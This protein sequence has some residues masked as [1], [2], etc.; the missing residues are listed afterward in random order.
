[1]PQKKF[2]ITP[3][4]EKASH[5]RFIKFD[6]EKNDKALSQQPDLVHL[7][8]ESDIEIDIELA[9]KKVHRTSRITVTDSLDPV[10][11][12][13]LHDVLTLPDGT[14]KERPHKQTL[15][16]INT[17]IPVRISEELETPRDLMFRYLFRKS[18]YITHY[19][20]V[21]YK[22]L[23]EIAEKL[24]KAKKFARVD[25]FNPETNKRGKKYRLVLH[26][27]DQELN[28]TQGD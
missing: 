9:G 12:Y 10:Y 13:S 8:K 15:G 4:G 2:H 19:D 16:N 22:F 21:T 6:G 24:H 5:Q 28:T 14:I 20:G 26:L 11:N 17:T 25:T 1:S 23:F 18:Y 27:S 7:L 3:Q